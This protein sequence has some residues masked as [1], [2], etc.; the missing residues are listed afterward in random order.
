MTLYKLSIALTPERYGVNIYEIADLKETPATY[1][2]KGTR[3][4]KS[5]ILVADT[6]WVLNQPHYMQFSTFCLPED[7]EKAIEIL[8]DKIAKEYSVSKEIFY[9]VIDNFEQGCKVNEELKTAT[10]L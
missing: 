5:K 6:T 9:K 10:H 7:K 1:S 8:K 2:K 4:D 3:I